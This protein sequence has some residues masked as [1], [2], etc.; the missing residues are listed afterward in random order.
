MSN[1]TLLNLPNSQ[2]EFIDVV[3]FLRET[4][5]V[6]NWDLFAITTWSLWNN[7][8]SVKHEGRCKPAKQIARE[9]LNLA[10]EFW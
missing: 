8:N 9:A 6:V 3:W 2:K 5:K 4:Q 1:L 7:R 10:K